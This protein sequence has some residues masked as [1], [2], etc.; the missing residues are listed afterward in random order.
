MSK[1]KR[2]INY[3][4]PITHD[5]T[6]AHNTPKPLPIY[7][8]TA[9]GSGS[10]NKVWK[11]NFASPTGLVDGD[12]YQGPWVLKYPIPSQD[13]ALNAM[14]EK[15]RAVR[16][17]N[18]INHDLPRAGLFKKGWVAPYLQNTRPS[19][20]EEIAQ[21][22][23]EIYCDT[24]RV[25]LDAATKGNF[26]TDNDTQKVYLVDMDL[27]LK[28]RNSLA[29]IHFAQTLEK[30]FS[31]YWADPELKKNM[32]KTLQITRNLL[33]L[34]DNLSFEIIDNLCQEGKVTLKNI[35]ALT[36]FRMN[37]VPLTLAVFNQITIL[38]DSDVQITNTMLKAISAHII[39]SDN[40]FSSL[41]KPNS[42]KL[43]FSSPIF[44]EKIESKEQET[45]KVRI[46]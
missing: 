6:D 27:A 19:T 10:Y 5:K 20:D 23:I 12:S 25:V 1:T 45:N 38:N 15:Q 26:L 42:L 28:R 9:I 30:R 29:S 18:E 11:S 17:W 34:E 41:T 16:L 13:P 40:E 22:L 44:N 3:S 31:S 39:P 24:K 37:K 32:P 36:W 33:F 35:Q 43:L 14:N 46:R 7:P 2:E 21:K 8:W 4:T